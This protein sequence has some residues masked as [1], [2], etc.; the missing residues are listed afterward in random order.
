MVINNSILQFKNICKIL[1]IFLFGCSFYPDPFN[2]INCLAYGVQQN[3]RLGS[4]REEIAVPENELQAICGTPMGTKRIFVTCSKENNDGTFTVY[5]RFD[6]RAARNHGIA[7]IMCGRQHTGK[8]LYD[9]LNDH[10]A[11]YRSSI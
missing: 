4:M 8:Y 5:Y 7:H 10:P 3:E 2:S 9:L 1:F 11:P 6:D